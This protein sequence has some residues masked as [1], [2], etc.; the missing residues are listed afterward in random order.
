MLRVINN[1][2]ADSKAHT[3]TLRGKTDTSI[4]AQNNKQLPNGTDLALISQDYKHGHMVH[5]TVNLLW[6]AITKARSS[7]FNISVPVPVERLYMYCV[8]IRTSR[9]H[10][11]QSMLVFVVLVI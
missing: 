9:H 8:V 2:T 10:N 6:N 1:Q 4:N 5:V 11:S 3:Q 7:S